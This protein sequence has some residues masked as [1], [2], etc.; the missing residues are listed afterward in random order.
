MPT[1][2]KKS[3]KPAMII[4]L[5]L[6]LGGIYAVFFVD[7]GKSKAPEPMPARPLK[8]ITVGLTSLPPGR[9]YPG[10]VTAKETAALAFQVQGQIVELPIL[11]GQN[12]KKGEVLAKLD[13]RDY[14][15]QLDAANAEYEQAKT[16]FERIEK[17]A[18]TGAVSQTDLTNAKADF[19]KAEAN[20]SIAKKAVE[21]TVIKAPY[22]AVVSNTFAENFENVQA[23][24]PIIGVQDISTVQVEVAVPQERVLKAKAQ[25]DKF[26]YTATFDSLPEIEFNVEV[27]EYTTEADPLTQTYAITFTMPAQEDYNVFPGMTATVTEIPK[28][29]AF[30]QSDRLTVPIDTVP[31]DGV[32]NYYVWKVK[33]S[34]GTLTVQR[35][36]VTVG[37]A[38]ADDIEILTG[39]SKGDRIAAQGVHLLQE[40]QQVRPYRIKGQEE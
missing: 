17:A 6:I 2:S 30:P 33:E 27:K 25:R 31:I 29:G 22:N 38:A 39:L 4:G 18:K 28:E 32:G 36:N 13:E 21:D 12:V 8:M 24:Q 16:Q 19:E 3:N 40:G 37:K 14:R 20:L 5:I 9:E 35:Q 7:W 11:K 23:K 1:T 26:R 15:N 10:K 34:N